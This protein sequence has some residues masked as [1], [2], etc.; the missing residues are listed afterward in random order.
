MKPSGL[1]LEEIKPADL[2][3]LDFDGRVLAGRHPRHVEYPIH[4][5]LFR[6]R[7]E[8]QAVVHTHPLA[9]TPCSA[10]RRRATSS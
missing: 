2:L 5:E 10:S 7:P 8:V 1:G 9:A 3:L 4:A 6:A